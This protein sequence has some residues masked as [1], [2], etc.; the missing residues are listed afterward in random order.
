MS[1][2]LDDTAAVLQPDRGDR[3]GPTILAATA[4]RSRL[5][6]TGETRVEGGGPAIDRTRLVV[7]ADADWACNALLGE[8]DNRRLF[9]NAL[10]W[11]AGEE[12]LVAVGGDLP[13]LR[14][15][16]LT[17][18]R[19]RLLGIV[20]IGGLPAAGLGAGALCWLLHRRR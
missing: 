4:D 1:A 12:D 6:E 20:S 13:D 15:L 8:L 18:E 16:E 17:A 5:S 3:A 14:R 9:V 19:R 11:L 2:Q 7:V 10:N